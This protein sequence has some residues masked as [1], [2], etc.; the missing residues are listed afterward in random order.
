[1][2]EYQQLMATADFSCEWVQRGLLFAYQTEKKLDAYAST[3]QL[4]SDQ[5]N[6]PARRLSGSEV[7]ALEP[8]LR[9]GLAGAWYY[10]HDAHLRPNL[11]VSEMRQRLQAAG[12]VFLEQTE[13][14]RLS[15][16]SGTATSLQT[17][18]Q[19]LAAD[20]FL[21]ACGAWTPLMSEH[22]GCTIPIQPGKGY[23]L[24][25][26]R[27]SICPEIPL[28]FPEHRVAVTPMQSAL[29]LGSIME[30][31]GYDESL[32]PE[33]LKLL[34][35]GAKPYLKEMPGGKVDET[36]YGWRPMTY[37]SLPVIDRSP[38]WGNVWVASGHNMLG[39]TMAPATGRLVAE[40]MS[41]GSPHID[42][43]PYRISRF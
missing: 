31:S 14:V 28:I 16:S 29:R 26:Q 21:F 41:S 33:R 5:F 2:S 12:V 42:P 35:E 10:E 40:L 34:T 20:A 23:S 27:P 18:G 6:E 22:L 13:P 32:R 9:E 7:V 15:G 30:F 43:T 17:S 4:L 37:D 11:L 24:T 8:A 36:W 25:F 38:R 1:M 3:N 39:L 19:T